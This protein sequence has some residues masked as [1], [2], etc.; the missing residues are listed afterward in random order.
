MDIYLVKTENGLTC[1]TDEDYEKMN[2]MR[3]GEVF[4]FS[5]KPQRN[6]DFHKKFFALCK[7]GLEY[8]TE[9]QTE[10]FHKSLDGFRKSMTITA[11]YYDPIYDYSKS[12]WHHSPKSIQFEKMDELEFREFYDKVKDI[13]FGLIQ[14][15]I[16]IEEF[17]TNLS[18]F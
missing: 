10:Y 15:K 11:G 14:H 3:I 17:E 12:Q 4:K 18:K 1:A 9:N 2:K 6:Y 16:S 7:I 5:A 8:M 13:I